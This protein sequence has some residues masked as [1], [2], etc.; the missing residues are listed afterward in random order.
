MRKYIHVE[1]FAVHSSTFIMYM[2]SVIVLATA[3]DL[4]YLTHLDKVYSYY[5]MANAFSNFCSFLS[6]LCLCYIF[7]GFANKNSEL[8]S[9]EQIEKSQDVRGIK[10]KNRL[11]QSLQIKG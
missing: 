8:L 9:K 1:I 4:Y 10:K 2:L 3:T 5:V 11:S 6:H 7:S